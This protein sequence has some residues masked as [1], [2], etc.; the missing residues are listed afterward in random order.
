MLY[1][2]RVKSLAELSF[3]QL[4][5]DLAA[6][7]PAP[8]GGASACAVGAIAA[9]QAGM[10]VA[11][12]IGKKS[13][14]AHQD[15][16]TRASAKLSHFSRLFLT[17]GDEDAQAYSL[18]NDLQRLPEGDPRRVRE[19]PGAIRA[20]VDIPLAAC[21]ASAD[22]VRLCASLRDKTNPHL[23]S[24]LVIASI[25]GEAAA[26]A[27]RC[28]VLVNIPI[29]AGAGATEASSA[30]EASVASAAWFLREITGA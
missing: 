12:S 25:L 10:V 20:A 13:L 24:D 28:N 18:V 2:G 4:L 9:A 1:T 3:G 16:L 7:S 8:G 30:C 6:K 27:C 23:R 15:E 5:S 21:A 29:L 17:L 26:R 14:A 11:Y 22:L 19:W